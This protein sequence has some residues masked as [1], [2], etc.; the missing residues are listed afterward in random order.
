MFGMGMS[1][2][3]VILIVALIF[4]GPKKLPEIA[5]TL[6]RALNEFRRATTDLKDA[7]SLE[8]E[9]SSVKSAFD[10]INT[11]ASASA[12]PTP[13]G[14]S[15]EPSPVDKAVDDFKQSCAAT[16]EGAVDATPKPG[17]GPGDG[18]HNG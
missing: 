13:G 7:I 1:E 6:G 15:A 3:A 2:V 12:S 5:K 4:I 14:G 10:Q 17:T 11:P 9:V 18:N 16:A 8:G